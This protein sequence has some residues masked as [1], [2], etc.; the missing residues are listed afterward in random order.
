MYSYCTGYPDVGSIDRV[1]IM[2]EEKSGSSTNLET[3]DDN[4]G[5]RIVLMRFGEGLNELI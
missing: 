4:R 1:F 5:V 2:A 3:S